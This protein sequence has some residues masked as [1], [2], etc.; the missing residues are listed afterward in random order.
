MNK[1]KQR[2]K[3]GA[4]RTSQKSQIDLQRP[5]NTLG[6]RGVTAVQDTS[7]CHAVG[8]ADQPVLRSANVS[9]KRQG[10]QALEIPA[11]ATPSDPGKIVQLLAALTDIVPYARQQFMPFDVAGT[12]ESPRTQR[13]PQCETGGLQLSPWMLARQAYR[14]LSEDDASSAPADGAGIEHAKFAGSLDT[15]LMDKARAGNSSILQYSYSFLSADAALPCALFA[16][17]AGT[18]AVTVS[19]RLS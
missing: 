16:M 9:S 19:D 1:G 5:G 12:A 13:T 3:L 2:Q 11:S 15:R 14:Q 7:R 6:Q 17:A 10:L 4:V 18:A 8:G